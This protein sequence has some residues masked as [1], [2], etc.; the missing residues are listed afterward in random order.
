MPGFESPHT[1]D[2]NNDLL[3]TVIVPVYNHWDLVPTLIECLEA[4]TLSTTNFELILI[5]NGSYPPPPEK[6]WPDWVRLLDCQTPGSYAARNHAIKE[7]RAPLIAFT[8]ADCRPE[9]KWLATLLA[10][11]EENSDNCVIAGGITVTPKD[12]NN[13]GHFELY[14]LALGLPQAHYVNRG[15]GVTANLTAPLKLL[16]RLNGFDAQ[17]LSGG[18]A[19]FCRRATQAGAKLIYSEASSIVH[20]AR[21]TWSQLSAKTR[22]IKGGQIRSG[23][24]RKRIEWSIRTFIPPVFA[25]RKIVIDNRFN[26]RQKLIICSI[27]TGLW[28]IE[29]G[30]LLRLLLNGS[31]RRD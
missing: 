12:W 11:F 4:Q 29:V 24:I 9:Q 20:P 7:A 15:F 16:N 30:E 26:Q 13:I 8:D 17:R 23:T 10:C 1:V 14:D 22:R 2:H 5:D 19:D 28:F 21:E 6:Q 27:Q 31:P 18:D 25:W 3:I